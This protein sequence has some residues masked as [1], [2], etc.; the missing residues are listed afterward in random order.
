MICETSVKWMLILVVVC[1]L[2]GFGESRRILKFLDGRKALGFAAPMFACVW[3]GYS[4]REFGIVSDVGL[5]ALP[6]LQDLDNRVT[7]VS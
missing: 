1:N 7:I 3:F 5:S 4:E 6:N 2:I